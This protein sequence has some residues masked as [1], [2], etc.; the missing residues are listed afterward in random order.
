MLDLLDLVGERLHQRFQPRRH[1]GAVLRALGQRVGERGDALFEMVERRRCRRRWAMASTFSPSACTWAAS[2]RTVSLEAMW[3]AMSRSVVMACSSCASVA[4]SFCA[5]MRSILCARAGDRVVEAD[6]V[7]RR[8]QP[9]QR[10]AHFGQ[11]V[12]DAAERAGVD[13]GLAAFRD[14]LVEAL[15]LPLDGVDGAARHRVVERAA[16]LAELVAQRVDRL[17][18]AGLAQRLDLIGDLAKLIFQAGQVL[19]RQWRGCRPA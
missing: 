13:A 4:G 7:F 3:V 12:L 18:D 16:D 14:A 2:A 9:A 10:V 11:A 6:Q 17:L 8:H 1:R 5:T 19:R 15:D